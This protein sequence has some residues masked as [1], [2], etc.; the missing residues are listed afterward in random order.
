MSKLDIYETAVTGVPTER[1]T[2][3][4]AY[5]FGGIALAA[6]SFFVYTKIIK[7]PSIILY[8][9][10]KVANKGQF[11][12][13]NSDKAYMIN[14]G[15]RITVSSYWKNYSVLAEAIKDTESD[16]ITALKVSLFDAKGEKISESIKKY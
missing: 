14:A 9:V 8:K 10:D 12:L 3:K 2:K 7:S 15:Q 13:S 5:I 1:M 11:R 16:L 4:Q 6:V